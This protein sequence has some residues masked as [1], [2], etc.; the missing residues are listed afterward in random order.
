VDKRI[1]HLVH[2]EARR[3][4]LE[5][6]RSAPDGAKVVIGPA[7]RNLAQ[8]DALHALLGD[9]AQTRTWANRKWDAET[10]KRL[11]VG[12]WCRANKEPVVMLPALDGAG[13]EVVFRRTSTLTKAECSDLITFIEAWACENEPLTPA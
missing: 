8:N 2:P 6:L 1:F 10:W 11:L 12:A 9:I 4:A 5:A 7:N 13:V 3:R